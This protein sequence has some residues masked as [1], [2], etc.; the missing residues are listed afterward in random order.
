MM[1]ILQKVVAASGVEP[2]AA[3]PADPRRITDKIRV[4]LVDDDDGFRE[5][6]RGGL[7]DNGFE[8]TAFADGH[9][10]LRHL[11]DGAV[12]D[13]AV[14]DW[15]MPFINGIDLLSRMRNQGAA[16]PTIF[17]TGMSETAYEAKALDQGAVDFVDKSRGTEIL[18]KRIKLAVEGDG[19]R[20]KP[21][22]D[23]DVK[24][25][26]LLLRAKVGRAYWD[27]VDVNLTVTEYNIVRMLAA[28]A[29]QHST[30]RALY[31]C[32]HSE[33][34]IAGAGE[35]GYRTNVRSAMRRIRDK[36]RA[37]DPTFEE[38]ENYPSFGYRWKAEPVTD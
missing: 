32:V 36:F 2:E 27:G 20:V 31:D 12:A 25:G 4:V 18:T 11:A 19:V 7:M 22:D 24:R 26:R 34:F 29:G 17:L 21:S 23:E 30:Y 9:A 38:I 8:V 13:V 37:I 1:T 15:K 35:N 10:L 28:N 33:G 3:P 14:L 16:M 5:M 6:V